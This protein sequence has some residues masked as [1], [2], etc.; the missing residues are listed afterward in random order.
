MANSNIISLNKILNINKRN[1][2]RNNVLDDAL[3]AYSTRDEA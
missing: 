3:L 2:K 1:L